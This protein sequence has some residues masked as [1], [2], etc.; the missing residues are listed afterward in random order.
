MRCRTSFMHAAPVMDEI[1]RLARDVYQDDTKKVREMISWRGS[2]SGAFRSFFRKKK[3][4]KP[5]SKLQR[6]VLSPWRRR[7]CGSWM[8]ALGRTWRSA[9]WPGT[10]AARTICK[11]TSERSRRVAARTTWYAALRHARVHH[12]LLRARRGGSVAGGF[13]GGFARVRSVRHGRRS[14]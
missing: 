4:A 5:H 14:D 1:K 9:R 7:S 3:S 2:L 8:L 13:G 12:C 11:G 6:A 10:T